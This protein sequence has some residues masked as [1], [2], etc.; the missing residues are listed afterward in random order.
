MALVKIEGPITR[1]IGE[2]ALLGFEVSETV[3][4]ALTGQSWPVKWTV[5][6]KTFGAKIGDLV[7]VR[8]ELGI[9]SKIWYEADGTTMKRNAI[10]NEI[11]IVTDRNVNDP[12]IKVLRAAAAQTVQVDSWA[13]IVTEI[14][15]F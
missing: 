5:W 3:T 8:G 15:P 1:T 11:V 12:E 14:A 2:N 13:P 4:N 7:E 9:K 10:T 6:S